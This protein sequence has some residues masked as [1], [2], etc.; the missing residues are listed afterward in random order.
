MKTYKQ[1][2]EE[3]EN[4]D[5]LWGALARVAQ[6]GAQAAKVGAKARGVAGAAA[7]SAG[8]ASRATQ[9]GNT[10][11]RATQA[12]KTA[13]R[14]PS[15]NKVAPG[16]KIPGNPRL[17]GKPPSGRPPI[18]SKPD[19]PKQFADTNLRRK[20]QKGAGNLAKRG[21]STVAG[22]VGDIVRDALKPKPSET[23]GSYTGSAPKVVVK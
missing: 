13:S 8:T 23:E 9:A 22:T 18:T 6:M 16:S 21:L 15:G 12:G 5:E 17:K 19:G 1:F 20:L 2:N 7:R 11:S 10:A 4:L 3:V 14:A